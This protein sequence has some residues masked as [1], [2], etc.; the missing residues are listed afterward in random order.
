MLAGGGELRLF[1]ADEGGEGRCHFNVC[2]ALQ[3]VQKLGGAGKTGVG[4]FGL[5]VEFGDA[6]TLKFAGGCR[7]GVGQG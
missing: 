6:G 7:A 4:F 1:P 3:L 5:A 2:G